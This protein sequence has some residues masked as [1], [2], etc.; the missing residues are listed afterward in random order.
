MEFHYVFVAKL[1]VNLYLLNQLS[2]TALLHEVF[3]VYDLRRECFARA[4]LLHG[5]A[6]REA[7]LAHELALRVF[8]LV[9]ELAR[10]IV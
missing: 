6:A 5:V 2:L 10:L 4:L 1:L 8:A 9:R 7:A 3:L